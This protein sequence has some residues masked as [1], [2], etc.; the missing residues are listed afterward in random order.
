[1]E[2]LQCY[3]DSVCGVSLSYGGNC[4]SPCVHIWEGLRVPVLEVSLLVG[5]AWNWTGFRYPIRI[6]RILY[7][8][9]LRGLYNWT[10]AAILHNPLYVKRF[11]CSRVHIRLPTKPCFSLFVDL[12]VT[13]FFFTLIQDK[14]I[15]FIV[16]YGAS[17]TNMWSKIHSQSPRNSPCV[18]SPCQLTRQ[19]HRWP[20]MTSQ[21]SLHGQREMGWVGV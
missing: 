14:T 19:A 9:E 12:L 18:R 16:C 2:M 6:Q 13:F 11:M 8:W 20:E 7:Q 1:M 15:Y 10:T 5:W 21:F 17:L 4:L 3:A